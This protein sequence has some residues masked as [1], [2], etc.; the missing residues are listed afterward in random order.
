MLTGRT[1]TVHEDALERQY[2]GIKADVRLKKKAWSPRSKLLNVLPVVDDKVL[3]K[4]NVAGTFVV[5]AMGDAK[6]GRES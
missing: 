3:E 4:L 1:R 5:F 2:K 6:A